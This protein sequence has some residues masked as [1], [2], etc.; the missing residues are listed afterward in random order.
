M[1]QLPQERLIL[2]L[3]AVVATESAVELALAY[4]KERVAF[5]KPL[6][7]KQHI[8]FELAEC[9]TP[10]RVA[11]TFVDDGGTNEIMKE[12]IARSL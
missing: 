6:F 3:G 2:A 12:I 11:R 10:A 7:A 9:A 1:T 4:T 8:K 5:G